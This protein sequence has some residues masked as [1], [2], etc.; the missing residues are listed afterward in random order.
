[1]GADQMNNKARR[2]SFW[3]DFLGTNLIEGT[4]RLMGVILAFIVI[5]GTIFW[6]LM[7]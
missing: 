2:S 6:A 3:D 7:K 1:M 5:F 4:V